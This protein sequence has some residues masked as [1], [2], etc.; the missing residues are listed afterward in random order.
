MAIL[1]IV[2][3]GKL[4]LRER[5]RDRSP[6]TYKKLPQT[7]SPNPLKFHVGWALPT[8]SFRA[9]MASGA[10]LHYLF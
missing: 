3:V 2:N 8:F 6:C 9:L 10:H 7:P 1:S 4:V 5:A